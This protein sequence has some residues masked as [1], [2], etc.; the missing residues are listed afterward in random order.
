MAWK[1]ALMILVLSACNNP[2]NVEVCILKTAENK[3]FCAK[4]DKRY[5]KPIV[6]LNNYFAMPETDARKVF[7][8][9]E[10]CERAEKP[11]S[12][13]VEELTE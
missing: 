12:Q 11:A 9:I 7:D 8:K 6:E 13:D 5:E 1:K 2:R 3:A 4:D 10:Q